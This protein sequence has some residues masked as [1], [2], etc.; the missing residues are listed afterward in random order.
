T[1]WLFGIQQELM[2][3][4]V[5]TMNYTGNKTQHMQAGVAF[6][7]VNLNPANTVTSA[8]P[9]PGFA[10]ENLQCDCLSSNYNALQVQLRHNYHRLNFEANYTW[11]HEIDDLVN[12]FSS[13]SDPF[14]TGLDRSSGDIDVRHNL[15]ASLV[16]SLP[17]MKGSSAL[18]RGV[19]GG[20]QTSSIVQTRSGLPTNITLVSGFFGN[21]VRPVAV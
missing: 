6:A 11:A 4:T 13:F 18:M 21:P 17:D 2:P 10:A 7:A 1:N 19:L 20:W 8:R 9:L 3:N 14:N 15:T 16:Y 12:V 5:L